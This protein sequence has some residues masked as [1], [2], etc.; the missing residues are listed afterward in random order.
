MLSSRTFCAM[1]L[2]FAGFLSTT[3]TFV[4]FAIDLIS[5]MIKGSVSPST[6]I[7]MTDSTA[8]DIIQIRSRW[9]RSQD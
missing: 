6:H 5:E 2:L 4:F 8:R 3:T 9:V 1:T 7:D